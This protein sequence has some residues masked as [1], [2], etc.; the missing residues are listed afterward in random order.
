MRHRGGVVDRASP[1]GQCSARGR[2]ACAISLSYRCNVNRSNRRPTTLTRACARVH[3]LVDG[4]PGCRPGCRAFVR[5]VTLALSRR[6]PQRRASNT[7]RTSSAK[8]GRHRALDRRCVHV[9][10]AQMPS[11]GATRDDARRR[12]PTHARTGPRARAT[13]VRCTS[14]RAEKSQ[15][16][17]G[18]VV[19]LRRLR[20]CLMQHLSEVYS[21]R[22][23][24]C[25]RSASTEVA[26][27]TVT[28]A[29][30]C[31]SLVCRVRVQCSSAAWLMCER[32]GTEPR[33]AT[34]NLH[35]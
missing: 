27:H 34:D 28:L 18:A 29:R 30:Q 16:G 10:F 2:N 32:L 5:C 6:H 20:H 33:R 4:L 1:W 21:R 17:R 9:A 35:R 14:A 19:L 22:P 12:S 3:C 8:R 15:H 31:M 23:L 25:E 7:Q 26:L 11:S 13:G 24:A